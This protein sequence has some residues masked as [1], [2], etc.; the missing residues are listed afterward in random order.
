M[1]DYMYAVLRR[2]WEYFLIWL[3]LNDYLSL[4]RKLVR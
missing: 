2:A 1:I 3:S 4:Q